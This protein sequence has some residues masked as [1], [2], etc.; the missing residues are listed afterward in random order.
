MTS[1]ENLRILVI[2]D[3]SYVRKVISQI[4]SRLNIKKISEVSDGSEGF[5]K[6]LL[7][8]PDLIL[9]DI[10]ME[11]VDGKKFLSTLRGV[12]Q[13]DIAKTPVVLLTSD[14]NEEKVTRA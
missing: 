14:A 6:T 3:E 13:P 4:L 5:K 12:N 1:V 11:P 8:R 10:H 9:C 7:L 2:E